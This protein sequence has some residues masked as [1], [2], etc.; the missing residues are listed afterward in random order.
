[1]KK[2]KNAF[3]NDGKKSV[4]RR[5]LAGII[6]GLANGIFGAGGGMVAVPALEKLADMEAKRA[7]ASAICVILPLSLAT[8]VIYAMNNNVEWSVLPY[9]APAFFVGGILGAKLMNKI[10]ALWLNRFFSGLMAVAA[11]WM[12]FG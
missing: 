10:N 7:H 4:V 8:A 6:S 1:M 3:Q 12:L 11:I 9:V 2:F 5:L